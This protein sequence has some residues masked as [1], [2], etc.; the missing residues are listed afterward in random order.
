[1]GEERARL[2]QGNWRAGAPRTALGETLNGTKDEK[3]WKIT[4][5]I[6]ASINRREACDVPRFDCEKLAFRAWKICFRKGACCKHAE[7]LPRLNEK[8]LQLA[9]IEL[10][11]ARIRARRL[12]K[13]TRLNRRVTVARQELGLSL[14][15][16]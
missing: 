7:L 3:M 16:I 14:I 10:H 4:R 5:Q 2:G 11:D 13:G 9:V 15:H 6:R 1:M 8:A 12:A